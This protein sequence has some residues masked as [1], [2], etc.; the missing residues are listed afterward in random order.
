M[1][2][3]FEILVPH[4][5]KIKL[6]NFKIPL[7]DWGGQTYPQGLP[8]CLFGNNFKMKISEISGFIEQNMPHE[9]RTSNWQCISVDGDGLDIFVDALYG[10]N[11]EEVGYTLYD[12]L[13]AILCG[14]TNWMVVY[15]P[16]YDGFNKVKKGNIDDVIKELGNAI[17]SGDDNGFMIY[18]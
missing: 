12:L 5:S 8:E 6:L 14:Q 16:Q 13:T 2:A 17:K 15:E 7:F 1:D 18:S 3:L 4:T 9:Y 11:K 10:L